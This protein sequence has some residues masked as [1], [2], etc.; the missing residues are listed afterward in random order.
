MNRTAWRNK[1]ATL[2]IYM[3]HCSIGLTGSIIN[4]MIMMMM[5]VVQNET[6]GQNSVIT[7]FFEIRLC[8]FLKKNKSFIYACLLCVLVLH[9]FLLPVSR[10]KH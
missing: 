8:V 7:S 2:V 9:T 5:V 6:L 10:N 1:P 4:M 3:L